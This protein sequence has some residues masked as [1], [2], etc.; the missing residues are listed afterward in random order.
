MHKKSICKYNLARILHKQGTVRYIWLIVSV[1]VQEILGLVHPLRMWFA[2]REEKA[3]E[4]RK[5]GNK[6]TEE[7]RR[8]PRV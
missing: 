6:R 1:P 4:S 2:A 8:P 3:K 5:G 7:G